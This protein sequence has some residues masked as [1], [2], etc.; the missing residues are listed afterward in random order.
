MS[1][2][3]SEEEEEEEEEEEDEEDEEDEEEEGRGGDSEG[4]AELMTPVLCTDVKPTTVSPPFSFSRTCS[5][6]LSSL[7][8]ERAMLAACLCL[9]WEALTD[10]DVFSAWEAGVF[11][12]V[13][14]FF[15]LV[16]G[17]ETGDRHPEDN[18]CFFSVHVFLFE[19][20]SFIFFDMQPEC[21]FL[22]GLL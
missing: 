8:L 10:K 15:Q 9:F 5:G 12:D 1:E 6:F 14:S 20:C 22:G 4:R 19:F 16:F 17:V 7:N 21:L 13:L 3:V 2:S 11:V 18:R